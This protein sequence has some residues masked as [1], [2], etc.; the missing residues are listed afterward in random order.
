MTPMCKVV[1]CER[2]HRAKG[3][4]HMHHRR[5]RRTGE[6]GPI[7]PQADRDPICTIDECERGHKALGYCELH[8]ERLT[9]TGDVGPVGLMVAP[10]GSGT[11]DAA[12]YRRVWID[13]AQHY[14]HRH[15]METHLSRTLADSE[16]VHHINGDKVDNRIENLELWST[17][18]PTG[19]R[20]TDL[21]EWAK[22]FVAT[23][24]QEID[25]HG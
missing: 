14:E 5:W 11:L 1:G 24:E 15:I 3:Y 13:G 2:E 19:Q 25:K 16:S 7:E 10:A 18:Q 21:Y 4:C 8:Y 22:V 23:Y 17:R 9:R 20:V 12:G 6:V